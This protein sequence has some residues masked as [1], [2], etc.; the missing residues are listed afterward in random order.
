MDNVVKSRKTTKK[1]LSRSLARRIH[2]DSFSCEIASLTAEIVSLTAE[3][4]D[5]EE[6]RP[7]TAVT[8]GTADAT[9]FIL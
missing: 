6:V 5:G 1:H 7:F 8:R 9:C 4:V 2:R 3:S